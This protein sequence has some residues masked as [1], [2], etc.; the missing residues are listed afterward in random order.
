MKINRMALYGC[1]LAAGL[2][3]PLSSVRADAADRLT[4]ESSFTDSVKNGYENLKQDVKETVDEL[5]GDDKTDRQSYERQREQDLHTYHKEIRD[6]RQEYVNKRT[7]AQE[8][9]LKHHKR[10]PVTENVKADLDTPVR[11]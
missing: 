10:L 2:V 9:Y 11:N 5:A 8:E 1:L 3:L 6:A 4:A 7:R